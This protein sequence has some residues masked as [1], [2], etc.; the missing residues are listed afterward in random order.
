MFKTFINAFKV[1]EVRNK[2]LFTFLMLLIIRFGC[3]ISAPGV[4][5][6]FVKDNSMTVAKYT[7]SVAK[8]L[9]GSIKIA[10]FTRFEKGEGLEKRQDDFAA[11]VASM[12]K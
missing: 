12:V 11:E 5:Q 10:K 8:N 6:E 3:Q 2:L 1:K 9:G 7:E 4:D